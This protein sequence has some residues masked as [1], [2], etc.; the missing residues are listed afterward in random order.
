MSGL[1]PSATR[2]DPARVRDEVEPAA[3]LAP[4]GRGS[5]TIALRVS[6]W[7]APTHRQVDGEHQH[8]RA[9]RRRA[10]H[11]V[12]RVAAVAHH[13]EL[14]PRRRGGGRGD[15]L[16]A[17]DRDRRLDERARPPPPPRA[18]PA[19][20]RAARTS[21]ASPTGA[22]TTGQRQPLA[23]HLDGRVA[24][25]HV[26]HHDLPQ[27]HAL[28]VAD[29]R[30]HRGLVVGAAVDVVEELARQPAPRQLAVVERR[31]GGDAER[32]IGGEPRHWC[33]SLASGG[34]A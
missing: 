23:E 12:L 5:P 24:D 10:R 18:R 30:P 6:R 20:R 22:S 21:R 15:L 19:P 32:A 27:Q 11:Q 4:S 26:A 1:P 29:V 13:V 16:D 33:P 14:E 9:D 31:G 2:P 7:R 8:R 34:S 17:A 3:R 25:A 28:E